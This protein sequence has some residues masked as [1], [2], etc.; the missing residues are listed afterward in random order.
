MYRVTE[1][2]VFYDDLTLIRR[3]NSIPVY[4]TYDNRIFLFFKDKA[5]NLIVSLYDL[6]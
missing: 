5:D 6:T 4:E 3:N 1:L 2:P